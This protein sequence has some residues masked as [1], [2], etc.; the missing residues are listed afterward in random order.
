MTVAR[1]EG[2]VARHWISQ[3]TPYERR[4]GTKVEAVKMPVAFVVVQNA[5]DADITG[6][7]TAR[8]GCY[9]VRSTDGIL[10]PVAEGTFEELYSPAPN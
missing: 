9:L 5:D 6:E 8:P 7:L 1:I 4:G 10:Y 2:D 3:M